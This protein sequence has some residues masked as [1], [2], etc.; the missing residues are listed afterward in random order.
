MRK[1][2]RPVPGEDSIATRWRELTITLKRWTQQNY[3]SG[4]IDGFVPSKA[5]N[6][7]FCQSEIET[8]ARHVLYKMTKK[9]F[10]GG[11]RAAEESASP[12]ELHKFRIIA[13]QFRY[14]LELFLPIC[15][16]RA[17]MRLDQIKAIQA[18][19]GDVNDCETVRLMLADWGGSRRLERSLKKKEQKNTE[20]F[21]QQWTDAFADPE[22]L[23]EWL[24]DLQRFRITGRERPR[25]TAM[26]R[27]ASRSASL[28]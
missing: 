24:R 12:R 9:F 28:A 5:R 25:P 26:A 16:R 17:T 19:L 20:A 1:T 14:T 21:R 11:N 27:A 18:N 10:R 13:K 4:I 23:H 8:T 15:G 2:R 3:S 22:N 7:E 6:Q